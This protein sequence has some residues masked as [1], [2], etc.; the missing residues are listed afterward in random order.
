MTSALEELL[1]EHQ[2]I[3]RLSSALQWLSIRLGS[4]A[5]ID[6]DF[7]SALLRLL[8]FVAKCH[9]AREEAIVFPAV[10]P[11]AQELVSSAVEEHR[12]FLSLSQALKDAMTSGDLQAAYD[13]AGK[14]SSLLARHIEWE[15]AS[16]FATAEAVLG[17]EVKRRIAERLS[18]P[19]EGCSL[20]EALRDS[21]AI[22][23]SISGG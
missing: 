5:T 7:T 11:F 21:D 22:F 8:D 14:V 9:H 1:E 13:L 20:E 3:K 17:E 10:E 18:E 2:V 23:V 12:D 15:E 19:W 16:L 6:E 4:N